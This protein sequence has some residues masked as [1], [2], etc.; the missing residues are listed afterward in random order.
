M[1]RCGDST[2]LC[3]PVPYASSMYDNLWTGQEGAADIATEGTS[4]SS[5]IE[6][7]LPGFKRRQERRRC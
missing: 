3:F 2:G 7:H 6:C 5:H 4:N 1:H